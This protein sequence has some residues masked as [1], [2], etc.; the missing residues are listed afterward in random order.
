M[1]YVRCLMITDAPVVK[2][3]QKEI[4]GEEGSAALQHFG[5]AQYLNMHT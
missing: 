4:R 5:E 3:S 1:D 2:S